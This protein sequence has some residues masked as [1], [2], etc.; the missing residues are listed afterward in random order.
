MRIILYI[1]IVTAILFAGVDALAAQK[2]HCIV[3]GTAECVEW[4][5][6]GSAP[7][8]CGMAPTKQGACPAPRTTSNDKTSKTKKES[9]DNTSVYLNKARI[10]AR[11]LNPGSLN[12]PTDLVGIAMKVGIGFVGIITLSLYI[13]GGFLWATSFGNAEKTSKAMKIFIWTTAGVL[14]ML[15]SYRLV[16]FVIDNVIK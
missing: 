11:K 7:S 12:E 4:E 16:K 1:I 5:S 3:P 2:K 9:K 13:W 14:A 15:I 6:S 10:D 8:K